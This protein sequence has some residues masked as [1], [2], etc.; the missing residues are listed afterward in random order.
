MAAKSSYYDILKISTEATN[1][2]V[3]KAYRKQG[4]AYSEFL[5]SMERVLAMTASTDNQL[6][7]YCFHV[8]E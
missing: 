2:E 8:H 5:L 3:R 6:T 1:E 7:R 4:E